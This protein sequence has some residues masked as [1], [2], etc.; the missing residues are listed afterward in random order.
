MPDRKR[1]GDRSAADR[2]P[3]QREADHAS[4]ARLSETLLPAL[5][6]KLGSSGL[7]ELEVHEGT[8]RVRLRRTPSAA[9]AQQWRADRSRS[10]A[11]GDRDAR[12]ARDGTAGGVRPEARSEAP[13]D[14][15]PTE[16]PYALD[17][18]PRSVATSPTVGVFRRD[19]AVGTWVQAGDRVGVV[20]LLGI[21]QDVPSP[22][23][24][25][26]VEVFPDGGEAVEFGEAIAA[27]APDPPKTR[28]GPEDPDKP[29]VTVADEAGDVAG[30]IAAAAE[31][32]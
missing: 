13:V 9:P 5:V 10:M 16:D 4:L 32:G 7:G 8:W 17:D 27:V 18:P 25:T 31:S 2:T 12:S 24:G 3:A 30:G 11:H 28:S 22:V 14:I 6:E 15:A 21:P 20:D 19:V 26:L 1:P 29:V 23:D